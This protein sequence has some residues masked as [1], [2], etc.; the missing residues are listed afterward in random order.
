MI[1]TVNCQTMLF[2]A[3]ATALHILVGAPYIN[4]VSICWRISMPK[5]IYSVTEMKIGPAEMCITIFNEHWNCAI[6]LLLG[7]T[8]KIARLD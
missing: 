1:T 8:L 4:S 5:S 6:S 7:T 3:R 2:F